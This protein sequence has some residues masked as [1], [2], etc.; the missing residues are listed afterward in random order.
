MSISLLPEIVNFSTLKQKQDIS[1][2]THINIMLLIKFL[3][4]FQGTFPP[5]NLWQ[6]VIATMPPQAGLRRSLSPQGSALISHCGS[7]MVLSMLP[8]GMGVYESLMFPDYLACTLFL[9]Q[10][11]LPTKL[12]PGRTLPNGASCKLCTQSSSITLAFYIALVNFIYLLIYL[13][14]SC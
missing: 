14:C 4:C 8:G 10:E 13:F 7:L 5:N 11:V 3:S 1:L 2:P 9:Y 12:S 6:W